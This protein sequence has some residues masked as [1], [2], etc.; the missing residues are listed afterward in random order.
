MTQ[1]VKTRA[2]GDAIIFGTNK[3]ADRPYIGAYWTGEEW[4]PTTWK[5]DGRWSEKPGYP[6]GLDIIL[7]EA[8]FSE[9][10]G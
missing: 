8:T 7:N 1:K 10:K 4:V 5:S 3:L 9:I 2:G 6:R